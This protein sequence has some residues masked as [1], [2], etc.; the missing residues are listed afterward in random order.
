MRAAEMDIHVVAASAAV[1]P[2]SRWLAVLIGFA[3]LGLLYLVTAVSSGQWNPWKYVEGADGWASTS[4]LQWF[5]WIVVILFAYTTLWVLRADQGHYSAISQVPVNVLTVLGFSTGT[6]AAAKGI[7][8]AYVQSNRVSK[9][10][11]ATAPAGAAPPAGAAAAP[12]GPKPG[13]LNDDTGVPELA[14]IQVM[15]F[16]LVAIGIYLATVIHQIVSHPVITSL[17]N[18]DTSLL[19]LMGISQGGYLGKKLVTFGSPALYATDP[20]TAAAG[21]PVTLTGANLGASPV[22]SLLTL[23]GAQIPFTQWSDSTIVFDV[24]GSKPVTNAAW[25]PSQRVQLAVVVG[26]QTSNAI[27]FTIS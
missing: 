8:S 5:L 1:S 10:S 26:G 22:G 27:T 23:D 18:I 19:V 3:V 4:K 17:P 11:R 14:K 21:T 12:A 24:P 25:A 7:T 16:T 13:I 20:L 2:G 15:G 6:A 9:R